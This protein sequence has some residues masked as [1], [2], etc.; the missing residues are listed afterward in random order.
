M[1]E[2]FFFLIIVVMGQGRPSPSHSVFICGF[3]LVTVV[4][5]QSTAGLRHLPSNSGRGFG[6]C[7][8]C[9]CVIMQHSDARPRLVGW[10]TFVFLCFSF[11]LWRIIVIYLFDTFSVILVCFP[12][13]FMFQ[14]FDKSNSELPLIWIS[15]L[16]ECYA[17]S[18]L[19]SHSLPL[20]C[21]RQISVT[22]YN[23]EYVCSEI[24]WQPIALFE[25]L[26][27]LHM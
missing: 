13:H 11:K 22:L 19:K 18:A 21:L 14:Y 27:M 3:Q 24:E 23:R 26:F 10:V 25:K 20:K 16:V 5:A 6:Q 15:N 12:T 1:F 8:V 2:V 9:V 7:T 4:P 17:T